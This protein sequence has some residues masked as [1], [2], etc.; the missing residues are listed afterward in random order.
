MRKRL[1]MTE[2][3]QDEEV[4]VA[5]DQVFQNERKITKTTKRK[6]AGKIPFC[7]DCHSF[8]SRLCLEY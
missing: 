3:E 2:E 6:S 7:R 5:S 8:S 1:R 4:A